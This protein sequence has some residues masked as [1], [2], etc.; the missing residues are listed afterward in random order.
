M[1]DGMPLS[2]VR[3]VSTAQVI[4][5]S[6]CA[7]YLGDLG[8]DVIKVESPRGD[9]YRGGRELEG[10]RASAGFEQM[11]RNKRSISVDLK[12]DEGKEVVYDLIEDADVFLQN[13]PPG[14]DESLGVDYETLTEKNEDLIYVHVS[15]YGDTGPLAGEPAMDAAIQHA[16]GLSSI[17]GFEGDP[18]IRAQSSLA[19]WYSATNAAVATLAALWHRRNGGGGQKIEISMLESLMHNIDHA[20]EFHLNFDDVEFHRGGRNSYL[21]P[22]SLYGAAETADGWVCVAFYLSSDRVWRGFCNLLDRPDLLED[23]EYQDPANRV[24]EGTRFSEMLEDWIRERTS[25]ECLEEMSAEGIPVAPH[26]TIPEA[27]EMEHV[28][29]RDWFKEVEHSR[30]GTFTL[31]RPPFRLSE[32]DADVFRH[33]PGLGQQSSE[34]LREA[35]YSE[36]EIEELREGDVIREYEA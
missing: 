9:I 33:A 17:M 16:S 36:E 21:N 28:K 35:G 14:V 13:W 15:G 32:T 26:N 10:E 11:N 20:F 25:E 1:V 19:D 31:S 30:F 12:T 8:A 4:A 34:I 2:G 22:D 23:P 6:G 3:I 18:P 24:A 27:A 7:T 5:G 29:E